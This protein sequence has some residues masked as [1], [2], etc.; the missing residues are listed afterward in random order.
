MIWLPPE[1]LKAAKFRLYVATN[2]AANASDQRTSDATWTE[3]TMAYNSADGRGWKVV[4]LT[5]GVLPAIGELHL[6]Y[7]FG[8]MGIASQQNNTASPIAPADDD[9]WPT[10]TETATI[11]SIINK[12]IRLRLLTDPTN[13]QWTT[14]WWG[15]CD[16]QNDTGP[17]AAKY[18]SGERIAFCLDGFNRAKDWPLNVHLYSPTTS[19]ANQR[20]CF[21]HPG[22]NSKDSDFDTFGNMATDGA[23]YP[24]KGVSIAS[25]TIPGIGVQ[26]DDYDVLFSAFALGRQNLN[27]PLFN[28]EETEG[29]GPLLL[30]FNPWP[31]AEGMSTWDF[32]LGVLDRRR[33]NGLAFLDWE[34][35][36]GPPANINSSKLRI[37]MRLRPQWYTAISFATND[38][39]TIDLPGAAS[40]SDW[41]TNV[42][43][44]GDHRLVDDS[45]HADDIQDAHYDGLSV[46]GERIEVCATLATG[47]SSLEIS[48]TAGDAT[49][50]TALTNIT[51]IDD[52]WDTVYQ[53]YQ[54]PR[55]WNGFAKDGNGGTARLVAYKCGALTV[56]ATP[57]ATLSDGSATLSIA[58]TELLTDIP[59]FDGYRYNA[60]PAQPADGSGLGSA[61]R[62]PDR[63]PPMVL[64][65]PSSADRFL[66]GEEIIPPITASVQPDGCMI[67]APSDKADGTR[68]ISVKAT[69]RLGAV[70]DTA[71]VR[72]VAGIRLPYRVQAQIGDPDGKRQKILR[73]PGCHLWLANPG[74]IWDLD[75]TVG[76]GSG[77]YA[78]RRNPLI[79]S[80][81]GPNP[82]LLRDD[83]EALMIRCATAWKWYDGSIDRR[84]CRWTLRAHGLAGTFKSLTSASSTSTTTIAYP[85][86]GQ[87]VTTLTANGQTIPC[88][89][90][91][92]GITYDGDAG[93][94]TWQTEWDDLNYA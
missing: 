56:S 24:Y 6:R 28:I 23:P 12:E 79:V 7:E 14:V 68:V 36:T 74:T 42:D 84:V 40:N 66:F 52:R 1:Q 61:R 69:S 25:F 10:P 37:R 22:Y 90:P 73:V 83:R 44:I 94:T 5:R 72:L 77:G 2:F 58:L 16:R 32:A 43:L 89:T 81:T 30:S 31:V 76:D 88:N 38:G 21:G 82:A 39:G 62:S 51:C 57:V 63:R 64:L 48:W 26:W 78:P 70:F 60:V 65:K 49:A 34:D 8:R 54:L 55:S 75:T 53:K 80:G 18:P 19:A 35:D 92:T 9:A 85:K 93:E 67:Y 71:D 46:Q 3:E 4:K 33:G 15:R 17:G 13:N 59:L 41:Y 87:F 50:F 27:D 20:L 91:I 45:F 47:E 29:I 11:P 86:L